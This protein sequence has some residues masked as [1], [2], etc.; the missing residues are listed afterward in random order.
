MVLLPKSE[1]AQRLKALNFVVPEGLSKPTETTHTPLEISGLP[2][3]ASKFVMDDKNKTIFHYLSIV[4]YESLIAC[5]KHDTAA[6]ISS[7]VFGKIR[8]SVSHQLYCTSVI[9]SLMRY[10]CLYVAA[11]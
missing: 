10:V 2:L 5:L 8:L 11:L 9:T 3:N 4:R 7:P 1:P 6:V